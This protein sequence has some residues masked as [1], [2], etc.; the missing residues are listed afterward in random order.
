MTAIERG[1]NL[2]QANCARCHGPDGE[3]TTGGYIAPVLHDQSKLFDHLN[4]QYLENVLTVGGRYVVRQPHEPDAR[5]GG[6]ERWPPQLPPDPGAHRLPAGAVDRG[7]RAAESGDQRA[8]RRRGRQGQDVPRLGAIRPSSRT[9]APR[10][11]RPAGA[12]RPGGTPAPSETLRPDAEVGRRSSPRPRLRR[13]GADGPAG[14]AVRHRLHKQDAAWAATT[15][16]SGIRTEDGT[17][18]PRRHRHW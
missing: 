10:R 16:R 4:A 15:S 18:S 1:Y 17:A 9:R 6:H 14:D 7:V 5:L 13:H 2:Y 11:C 12:A 3:G 8:G